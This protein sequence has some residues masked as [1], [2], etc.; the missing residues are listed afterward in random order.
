MAFRYSPKIVTDGLVLYLDASNPK[1]II[2]GST[3]WNDISRGGNNGTLVN[4]PT[5]SSSNGGSISFDGTNDY[6]ICSNS[7]KLL[8]F[9]DSGTVDFVYKKNSIPI[10]NYTKLWGFSS[11]NMW[12]ENDELT[13]PSPVMR[14]VIKFN[15][16]SVTGISTGIAY[17][18]L[19]LY[20]ITL[21]YSVSG[22]TTNFNVYKNG[23]FYTNKSINKLLNSASSPL[24]LGSDNSFVG[25]SYTNCN[26]YSF[27]FYN[28]ALSANEILQNYNTTKSKFGL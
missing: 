21:V 15:D 4:G 7:T 26:I 17:N 10:S 27:K 6:V 25:G 24:Y 5:Y 12:Y 18:D 20:N 28:K 14:F 1:S 2:S 23:V 8:N 9:S 13:N 16:N 11:V 22:G 3:V 19:S